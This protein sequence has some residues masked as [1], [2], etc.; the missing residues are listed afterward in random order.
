MKSNSHRSANFAGGE[1]RSDPNSFRERVPHAGAD[2]FH[3]SAVRAVCQ[4]PLQ[5]FHRHPVLEISLGVATR[6]IRRRTSSPA[7]TTANPPYGNSR[8]AKAR[9][10]SSPAVGS[11]RKASWPCPTSFCLWWRNCLKNARPGGCKRHRIWSETWFRC[12]ALPPATGGSFCGPTAGSFSF[13]AM[14][15]P[16][17]APSNPASIG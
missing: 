14:P 6:K 16:L 12:R 11:R 2:R 5:R 10:M 4:P 9:S 1:A 17:R 7:S 13:P 15:R 3:A 8:W